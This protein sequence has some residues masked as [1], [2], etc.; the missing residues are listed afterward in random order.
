MLK[1]YERT[2]IVENERRGENY[3]SKTSKN[4]VEKTIIL[5]DK[6]DFE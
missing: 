1:T 4:R 5:A 2:W 3:S 6:M